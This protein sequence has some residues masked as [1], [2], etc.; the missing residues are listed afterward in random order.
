MLFCY[1]YRSPTVSEKSEENNDK[2]NQLLRTISKKKY[3]HRCIVGDFN[4]PNINWSNWS[5]SSSESSVEAKFIE[6]VRDCYL[7]Q[8]ISA[9]TRHRGTNVPSLIDLLLTDEEM[10]VTDIQH[11]SPLGKSDHNVVVFDFH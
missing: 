2:L 4:L 7:Y 6:A 11:H 3:T 5:T 1:C 10:N 8:H 9:T